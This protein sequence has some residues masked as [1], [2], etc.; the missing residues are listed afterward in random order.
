MF[1]QTTTILG[2]FTRG[3]KAR[4]RTGA[5]VASLVT[6]RVAESGS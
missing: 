6:K 2:S 4:S 5:R 3:Q 1:P